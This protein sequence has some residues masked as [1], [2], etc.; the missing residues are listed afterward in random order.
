MQIKPISYELTP[1]IYKWKEWLE[2]THEKFRRE[3]G[4]NVFIIFSIKKDNKKIIYNP[5]VIEEIRK[6]IEKLKD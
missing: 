4:G 6:E 3:V 2:K 5:E 1:E